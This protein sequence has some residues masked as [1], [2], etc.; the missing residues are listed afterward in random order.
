MTRLPPAA[1][2]CPW[3]AR[4]GVVSA[5]RATSVLGVIV[6]ETLLTSCSLSYSAGRETVFEQ[7]FSPSTFVVD[8]MTEAGEYSG[9]QLVLD[10]G[11]SATVRDYPVG[12]VRTEPSGRVCLDPSGELLS[13]QGSW[14]EDDRGHIFLSFDDSESLLGAGEKNMGELDWSRPGLAFCGE[15]DVLLFVTRDAHE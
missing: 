10:E 5:F 1:T 13:A 4:V 12:V 14:R 9:A 11:G 15:Q 3:T 2:R 8:S 7:L 6:G